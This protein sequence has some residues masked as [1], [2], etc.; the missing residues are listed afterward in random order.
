MRQLLMAVAVCGLVG[1]VLAAP[2]PKANDDAGP[3]ILYASTKSGNAEIFLANLDG[4]GAKNLTNGEAQ[5]TFPAWSPDGKKIAFTSDRDGSNNIY[6]MDADGKKVKQLTKETD[7]CRAPAWSPDGKKIAFARHVDG[8]VPDI[9]VM[10]AD[11]GN[12]VNVTNDPGYDA[13]PAWSPDGKKI[14]FASLRGGNMGFRLYTMDPDG[15]NVTELTST[16]NPLGFVYPAWSPDGKQIAF[17]DAAG[18]DIELFVC[19]ADGKHLKQLTKEGGR[20]S[21]AAWS[22]DGKKIAWHHRDD[23][24]NTSSVYVMDADGSNAKEV[25]ANADL[26]AEGGRIAWKPK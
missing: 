4:S 22:P 12:P 5:D 2:V 3:K 14:A 25:I 13:D 15:K 10:D 26:P 18:N 17:A 8:G 21:L 7:N 6:V 1:A 11:G 16:D 24:N 20:N 9:F 23:N 19:D